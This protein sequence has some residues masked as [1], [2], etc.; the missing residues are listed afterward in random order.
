MVYDALIGEPDVYAEGGVP[1]A[2]AAIVGAARALR[3]REAQVDAVENEALPHD[4]MIILCGAYVHF[5]N[6]ERP[7]AENFV[8]FSYGALELFTLMKAAVVLAVSDVLEDHV[9]CPPGEIATLA[10][11]RVVC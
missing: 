8:A 7:E 4:W 5:L 11:D 2:I 3:E 6:Q 9:R 1:R 10:I